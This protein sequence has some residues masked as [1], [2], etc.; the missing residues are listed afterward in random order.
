MSLDEQ[1]N[2]TRQTTTFSA[3]DHLLI[4]VEAF[5]VD[6]KAQNVTPGTI[7]YYRQKIK[8]FTDYCDSQVITRISQLTPD[9]LRRFLL[10]LDE[11]GHNPGGIHSAYRSLRAF[12]L[13][14]E[15]EA[16][17]E[18]WK[19]PIR[20]VKAPKVPEEI[21]EPVALETVRQMVENCP[22][23]GF[24]GIRDRALLWCLLDT[25]VR[26][27]ECLA[28]N[29]DDFDTTGAVIVRQGKGR[30]PRTVFLGKKARRAFRAY[31]KKRTDKNPAAWI[32]RH[33]SRLRYAGLRAILAYRAKR[34]GVP[35]PTAHDFRRAFALA[36]L[37]NGVDLITLARLM[38]HS[39]L[40]V[41]T[42]Y[43]RQIDADLREAHKRGG[44]ADHMDEGR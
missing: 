16:E 29:L 21:L 31:L 22:D 14:Y 28:L 23:V 30:K 3:Q 4:W 42:R 11:T 40:A 6:R 18:G 2:L 26:A 13:W 34:A 37:R 41:L 17:P 1:K 9:V 32:T 8:L 38:G 43:L 19:N 39:S 44:P 25:G 33:G 20:K 12:L 27:M 24:T 35:S 15:A 7:R 10:R 36:M 5:L